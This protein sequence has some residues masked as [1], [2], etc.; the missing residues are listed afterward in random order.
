M[1]CGS[2]R[3]GFLDDKTVSLPQP[4]WGGE[5]PYMPNAKLNNSQSQRYKFALPYCTDKIV[6]DLGGGDGYGAEILSDVAEK[7]YSTDYSEE[8][9]KYAKAQHQKPNIEFSVQKFPPIRFDNN[10]FDV[11]VT[12]E[13]IEHVQDDNLFLKA[14][15]S[16]LIDQ[17]LLIVCTPNFNPKV[18]I[19]RWHT[20]EYTEFAFRQLLSKY[21]RID[22]FIN[23]FPGQK[24]MA[25]CKKC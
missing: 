5:R 3:G 4:S 15:R 24:L 20:R 25:V 2:Q 16:V 1:G 18:G 12:L 9:I 8:A 21:F 14:I 22:K 7:V 17:G 19:G 11:V 6:L 13:M 23:D 10:S